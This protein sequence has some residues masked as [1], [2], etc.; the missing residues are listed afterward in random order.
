MSAPAAPPFRRVLVANRGEIA[1]RILRTLR[2]LGIE[3]VAV[4]SDAD[5]AAQHVRLA[6]HAVRLGGQTPAESYLRIDA[7]VD[8]IAR[9]GADAVHPGYGF[10]SENEDFARAVEAAG[11]AFIGPTPAQME[12]FGSKH[13]AR[14]IAVEAGVPLLPGTGVLRDAAHAAAEAAAIGYPVLLKASAGGGGIGMA[15]CDAPGELAAAF[16]R[17]ERL[18]RT[19]F[20]SGDVFLERFLAAPR[21]VEVQIAGDGRGDVLVLGDRDCSVQRRNQKVLEE[22][23]APDL[24]DRLRKALAESARALAARVAYRNVG[25]VE[26]LV[27]PA[28]GEHYFL[29]VN[30]RLQVEHGVTELCTGVDLVEWMLRI[31]AGDTAFFA[32]G[33][34][35][36]SGHAIEARLYAEDPARGFLPSA[37]LLTE[38]RYPEGGGVR[39]DGWVE[40]GTEVSA[41]YDPLLAKL[42]VRGPDRAAA[43]RALREAVGE[44]RLAGIET[45]REW[46]AAALDH[47]DFRGVRHHTGTFAALPCRPPTIEVTAAP[48]AVTVQDWPGRLGLW[49]VGV[50]PSGPMDDLSFRLGNRVVGNPA[51]AAGLECEVH[52]PTLVFHRRA[53]VCAA[54]AAMRV[55]VDGVEVPPW[56]P[57]EVDPGATVACGPV[58][59]PGA[60]AYLLFRGGLDVPAH[61]GSRATFTLGGFGGHAGRPLRPGDVLRLG[62]EIDPAQ[63]PAALPRAAQPEIGASWELGV[64]D[65][66]HGSPDFLTREGIEAFYAAEW[67]VHYH[68]ARTGVRLV[69]P[70]PAW[71]RTDGGEAGLHPSNL[72]DNAY[73]VG[74]VDLTGDMPV[75]LGP[76]GPSLGGFVCPLVVAAAERWKLGQLRAGDKVRF[77][78]IVP[79]EADA[80][81][82]RCE[83][84]VA[85]RGLA[86][87][88]NG[89]S[90][91]S[92][93]AA[94]GAAANGAAANGAAAAHAAGPRRPRGEPVLG[95]VPER[96]GRPAMVFRQSGDRYV[97]VEFG[98]PVL[99]IDLR[100]R[101]H[102]LMTR[103]EELRVP[104]VVDLTPGIRS[105][106]VHVDGARLTVPKAIDLLRKV[107]ADLPA[108]EEVHIPSR[109]VHMPLSWDDPATREAIARYQRAVRDDAPWCPSNLEFIRRVNGLPDIAA[110]QEI[111][112]AASYLVLGLGD[113]YL[114]APVA[115]PVDPRHR[116]VTTK[117]NPARTW[118]P[119]NAVG[120]GGAYLCVYGM[121]G[122]GG[123]QFL[124]RTVPVWSRHRPFRQTTR[125][126]P[127]LL[128]FFDQ[129]R[130]HLVSPEEL[131]ELRADMVAGRGEVH[132]EEATFDLGEHH[133]FLAGN[134]AGI[135]AAQARQRAAFDAERARWEA[136]GEFD[137]VR[138]AGA[139]L[140]GA[141]PAADD[142]MP[143]GML[144]VT[145]PLTACVWKVDVAPGQRV[146]AGQRVAVLEAMKMEF[147]V[148]ADVAGAVDWI[149][150]RPGQM[151]SAGQ[152]LVGVSADV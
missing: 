73:A 47:P 126:R 53:L 128:R 17:V 81:A 20:G 95:R 38:V 64:L 32:G 132:I 110:V 87:A 151:V 100:V 86:A 30:T 28:R 146:E 74:A 46:V 13:R 90:S 63:D 26:F 144:P 140:E 18:A 58:R 2:R 131:L 31:A 61:L 29:E 152:A 15:R 121:E 94:N 70:A 106:Q 112:L 68:S 82:A 21:H 34:P 115:T 138:R 10:L 52:G 57:V 44:T 24:P 22:A 108:P 43:V 80:L 150:C 42:L 40:T 7:V 129:L 83:A 37:G 96:D 59:G 36:L 139:R 77:R 124:G 103:L 147:A 6:D 105:L 102:L 99:D 93:A 33:D 35:P 142:A 62:E 135:R 5:R 50:P 107:E 104:G 27:D 56:T 48:G 113:V 88:T 9:S 116:L 51:G 141:A 12:A 145:A 149:G 114:G 91:A 75:I 123:Y 136:D 39:V 41:H 45:N 66:P 72:H 78:S 16:E 101:A 1:C 120:I 143:A 71:A 122:P 111:F 3:S 60:R 79:A 92:R 117:Y 125:E 54:G 65:G 55:L 119:E 98:P 85:Q 137:R 23:P 109:V 14:E 118:T 19:N 148:V 134:A 127:W 89:A 67:E 97:L 11:A 49:S 76:D 130:F 8:A 84:L 133:R 69:G 25:T 4:F